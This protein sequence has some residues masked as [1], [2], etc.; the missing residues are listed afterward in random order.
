ML[1]NEEANTDASLL[2]QPEKPLMLA[3]EEANTDVS[4][5]KKL[6]LMLAC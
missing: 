1:A 4:P 5:L 2:K 3:N 6:T